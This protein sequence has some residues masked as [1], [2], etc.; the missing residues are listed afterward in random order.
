LEQKSN[1]LIT[2]SDLYYPKLLKQIHDSPLASV[3]F[4]ITSGLALGIDSQSHLGALDAYGKT[5]AVLG[6]G[7][8]K[9]YPAANK[10]LAESVLEWGAIVS[11]LPLDYG[12]IPSNFP[13]RNRI[14]SGMSTAVLV[15]EA[16][17]KSGSLITARCAMV[18][19]RDVFAI[20]GSIHNP[21]ARGCHSLIRGG[22]KLVERI[23]DITEEFGPMAAV[24]NDINKDSTQTQ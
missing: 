5:L 2:P 18:E 6:N 10:A 17:L 12:P 23:Q 19:G 8:Q 24:V 7:L 15:V 9:I 4:T 21:M 20:P 13:R 14:V 11:E 16:A 3:G 1:F 22:A